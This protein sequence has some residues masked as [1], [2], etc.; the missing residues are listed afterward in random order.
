MLGCGSAPP[1]P[2]PPPSP[3]PSRFIEALEQRPPPVAALTV[4]AYAAFLCKPRFPDSGVTWAR[5]RE[6]LRNT[7]RQAEA[8]RPPA[9]MRDVHARMLSLMLAMISATAS[10][11]PDA[12]V[13]GSLAGDP[14]R[15]ALRAGARFQDALDALAD[16]ARSALT[17][18]GCS[19]HFTSDQP[20]R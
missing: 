17:E 10:F 7:H 16:G 14:H 12:L 9:A 20:G 11:D 2:P 6:V 15:H 1:A 18:A 13:A 19:F 8:I 5:Q 3:P 4:E